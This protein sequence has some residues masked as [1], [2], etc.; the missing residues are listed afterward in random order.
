MFAFQFNIVIKNDA[1]PF[2]I[3]IPYSDTDI[4]NVRFFNKNDT[5]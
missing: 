4:C 3:I 2:P 5:T 1:F